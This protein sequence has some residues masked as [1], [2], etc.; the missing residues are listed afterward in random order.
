MPDDLLLTTGERF[1]RFCRY[2]G[3]GSGP[4]FGLA[5]LILLTGGGVLV[6]AV[7]AGVGAFTALSIAT[8]VRSGRGALIAGIVVAGGLLFMQIVL[9]WL[10][11]HPILPGE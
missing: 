8:S 2:L 11:G 7:V 10:A 3:L 9:A 4:S 6:A 5:L 1:G